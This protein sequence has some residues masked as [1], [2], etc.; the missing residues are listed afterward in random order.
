LVEELSH[1][2]PYFFPITF[3]A[4]GLCFG[5]FAN[6]VILRMPEGK[7]FVA[8]RSRCP[9]CGHAIR[10]YENIP[11]IS[12]LFLRGKCSSCKT[13][14]SAR[15]PFVELLMGLLFTALY[16]KVGFSW[17]LLE[18]L[19]FG[20]SLVVVS[21]I[22][23]DH[24]ILP[25]KFT[26][27]GIVIGLAGGLLNP[28]RDFL[29]S[30]FG[31]LFGGGFLYAIAFIYF[32]IRKREGMGGGDIKLLGWI[33]ALLG[34]KAMPFVILMSSIVGAFVGVGVSVRNQSGLKASIPFGPYLSSAAVIY[35]LFGEQIGAWY[36]Q[37]FIPSIGQ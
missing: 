15:Y 31:V 8:P 35:I 37:A 30:V 1:Q 29:D 34:W 2:L 6:V 24:M 18:Y 7:S 4:L 23:L 26:L 28:E 32:A 22:D 19:L 10:S 36:L 14:I 21:F 9:K 17:T 20:F 11:V 13:P 33:G 27:S 25:D 5:S 12:W 3:F 16:L